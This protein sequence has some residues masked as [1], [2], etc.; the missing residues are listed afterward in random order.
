[1]KNC[2]CHTMQ[3]QIDALK[4][5]LAKQT[6]EL[7]TL[8]EDAVVRDLPSAYQGMRQVQRRVADMD[9]IDLHLSADSLPDAHWIEP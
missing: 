9:A 2:T 8:R 6:R 7:E 5:E 1:M 3:A 4:N